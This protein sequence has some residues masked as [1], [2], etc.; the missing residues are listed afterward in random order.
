MAES[1]AGGCPCHPEPRSCPQYPWGG[2][3]AVAIP[4]LDFVSDDVIWH[5][6]GKDE[7]VRGKD[8]T[9]RTAVIYHM[10]DGW[11]T[12][13]RAFSDDTEAINRFFA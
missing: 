11:V 8:F 5:V 9:Y 4:P 6:L 1:A 3:W 2:Y 7:P 10:R 12:E 13:C